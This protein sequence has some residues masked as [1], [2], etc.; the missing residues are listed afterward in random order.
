MLQAS[1]FISA[2]AAAS[3]R[4]GFSVSG[5]SG[6]L[7]N[8]SNLSSTWC[9]ESFDGVCSPRPLSAHSKVDFP[10]CGA[11][12][13]AR[14]SRTGFTSKA[15]PIALASLRAPASRADWLIFAHDPWL[16]VP[17]EYAWP[18]STTLSQRRHDTAQFRL[19]NRVKRQAFLNPELQCSAR[20]KN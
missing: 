16:S 7:Y 10:A 5:N 17:I 20:P 9:V 12:V 14:A 3:G 8:A 11:F 18:V 4:Y 19:A 2:L 1:V 13:A 6:N 15:S